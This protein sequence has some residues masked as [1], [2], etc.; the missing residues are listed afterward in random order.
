MGAQGIVVPPGQDPISA[1]RSFSLKLRG[2]ETGDSIMMFEETI[3]AGTKS[4]LHLHHDSDEVAYVLSGE[5]TF[6]IGDEVTV[7]GPGTCAFMPRG[8]PHAWKSTGAETGKVLFLYTPAKAGGL[9][10]EQQR[11]GRKFASMNERELADI[12]RRHGWELL[13]PSPF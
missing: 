4:T 3:P 7:G 2:G 9:I 1:G 13:G 6:K 8:V 11:T 12:L 10:E 5:V